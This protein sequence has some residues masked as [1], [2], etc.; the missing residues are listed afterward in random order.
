MC[1]SKPLSLEMAH[2]AITAGLGLPTDYAR[3]SQCR[4]HFQRV[5]RSAKR[6]FWYDWQEQV[7]QLRHRD[8]RVCADRIRSC[9][10][11]LQQRLVPHESV[12]WG[13]NSTPL[14]TCRRSSTTSRKSLRAKMA[15]STLLSQSLR[16]VWALGQCSDSATS[17][18]QA[19][20]DWWRRIMLD[21]FNLVFAWNAVPPGS[22]ARLFQSS[23]TEIAQ[24]LTIYRPISVASCAFKVFEHLIH[25]RIAPH[26]LPRPDEAQGGFRWGAD[27]LVCSLVDTLRLRQ[28]THRLKPRSSAWLRL[29]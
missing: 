22:P 4:L 6:K 24:I 18:F 27:A 25:G 8:P 15:S 29:A 7:A 21:F 2:G 1:A 13:S 3:F 14:G 20:L 12:E 26:I 5:V 16:F 23:N 10:R 28:E 9:F 17:V 11:Q 19:N